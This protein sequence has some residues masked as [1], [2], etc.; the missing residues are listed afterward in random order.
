MCS[1]SGLKLLFTLPDVG[2]VCIVHRDS[3]RRN[4][5]D[6]REFIDMGRRITEEAL[7]KRFSMYRGEAAGVSRYTTALVEAAED[8]TLRGGKRLRALLVIAGYWSR[9]WGGKPL[10]LIEG[11]LAGIEFLQS[12]LLVHDDIMDQDEVRRG[13]PTL[14]VWFRDKCREGLLGD[15]AHYGVSMAILTGDYLE[16]LAVASMAAADLPAERRV[17]II[18]RYARGLREVSYGQFLDVHMSYIPLERVG[19]EDV[20]KIHE[21]KTGSYTVELPLHIGVLAGYGRDEELLDL[22]TRVAKPIGIAFQL[23]DDIL[24]LYGDPSVTGKPVGSDVVEKKKTLLIVKAYREASG[25][26]REFLCR[27]YDEKN[28]AEITIDDIKRVQEIVRET[29]SLAYSEELIKKYYDEAVGLLD[30]AKGL[31]EK[32][33]DVLKKLFRLLVYREK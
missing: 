4:A 28:P 22:Y 13:G 11:L 32:A 18:E 17:L 33:R 10:S 12:Y 5:L 7:R 23:R 30:E 6:L 29:G 27:I 25:R 15:C 3:A 9:S 19:E 21:L 14:H 24:G 8:Y 16:A 26:D 31:D 2:V 1:G 20:L